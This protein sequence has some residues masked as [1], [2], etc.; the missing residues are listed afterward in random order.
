[1]ALRGGALGEHFVN[2]LVWDLL[3]GVFWVAGVLADDDAR[4]VLWGLAVL[5]TYIGGWTLHRLP[6]RGAR[7]RGDPNTVGEGARATTGSA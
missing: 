4:L 3:A 6:G 1:M 7:R 5:T 2:T